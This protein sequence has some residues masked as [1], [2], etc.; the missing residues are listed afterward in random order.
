[1]SRTAPQI[2]APYLT[3]PAM[4]NID[5]MQLTGSASRALHRH[6]AV[7][8]VTAVAFVPSLQP[9]WLVS[10]SADGTLRLWDGHSHQCLRVL[11]KMPRDVHSFAFLGY[12][13]DLLPSM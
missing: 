8:R 6:F 5:D 2:P 11:H 3:R 9:G 7:C 4:R 13:H 1:M 12:V 10:A